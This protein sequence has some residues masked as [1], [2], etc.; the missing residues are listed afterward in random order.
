[1][2]VHQ[3]QKNLNEL[4]V[5]LREDQIS[6]PKGL[7]SQKVENLERMY[8]EIKLKAKQTTMDGEQAF[9]DM[10]RGFLLAWEDLKK[11]ADQAKERLGS[12]PKH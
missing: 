6:D 7:M 11:A 4:K 12:T 8:E 3:A 10:K 5:K 2:C 9:S 1:M